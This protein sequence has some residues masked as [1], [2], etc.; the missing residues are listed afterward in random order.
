MRSFQ[1]NCWR[2]STNRKPELYGGRKRITAHASARGCLGHCDCEANCRKQGMLPL[3]LG[4]G[5]VSDEKRTVG[6]PF[7]G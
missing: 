3:G 5:S 6:G 7:E 1:A 2:S 4:G